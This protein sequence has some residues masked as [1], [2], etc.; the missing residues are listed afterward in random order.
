MLSLSIGFAPSQTVLGQVSP[1]EK[2][3]SAAPDDILA[4][5]ATSGGDSIKPAF[6]K[7]VTARMWRDPGVQSFIASVEQGL[8]AK[9][10]GGSTDPNALKAVE[11]VRSSIRLALTRPLVIGVAQK[12]V[13]GGPPIYGFAI[14]DA[15]PRKAEIV[16]A[17]AKLEA[18]AGEGNIVDVPVGSLTMHGPKDPGGVPGYWGWSGNHFVFSINDGTGLAMKHLQGGG[19]AASQ[20]QKV[21][22]A[23]DM[24]AIHVNAQKVLEI[25]SGFAQMQGAGDKFQI[26]QAVINELGLGNLKALTVRV[27]F[28]GADCVSSSLVEIPEPR[29]GLFASQKTVTLDMFDA[30]DPGAMSAT[31]FNYDMAGLYDTVMKAVKAAT[32]EKF[33]EVEKAIAGIEAQ[34]QIKIRDGLLKSLGEP[35]VFYSMPGGPATGSPQGVFALVGKLTDAKQW[36]QSITA[37]GQ[38]A[39]ASSNGMVQVSSQPQGDRTMHT[40][41]VLPLAMAQIMPSWCA[42][43]DKIVIASNPTFLG[44]AVNQLS[45]GK[46]SIRGTEGFKKVTAN[47]PNNLISLRYDDSKAQFNQIMM[48]LQQFW[49]MATMMATKA[50]FKLPVVLPNLSHIAEYMGPAVQYSWSDAQ[51]I[52]SHSRQVGL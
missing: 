32:G 11:N 43:G 51:G 20:L 9:I 38:F 6:D 15:G 2:L 21:P 44:S 19:P 35:M 3:A 39:A 7:T 1:A 17:L 42:V 48:S 22:G 30:V 13:Q 31:A 16:S 37:L 18:M 28:E 29:T 33:A 46:P 40:W 26:I 25:A 4:F 24:L 23:G 49:P 47:L 50:G 36:E 10:T 8:L 27:G 52:H 41:T 45:P 5:I 34:L 14:I 12:Q